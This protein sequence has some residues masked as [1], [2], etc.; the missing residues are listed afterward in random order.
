MKD[1]LRHPQTKSRGLTET[2][3]V[4][5]TKTNLEISMINLSSFGRGLENTIRNYSVCGRVLNINNQV[6]TRQ[7]ITNLIETN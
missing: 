4:T 5:L 2:E 3:F 7:N 6:F 1:S